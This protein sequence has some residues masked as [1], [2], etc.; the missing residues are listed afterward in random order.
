[1]LQIYSWQ[2]PC[3]RTDLVNRFAAV[4]VR[5]TAL[6][7]AMLCVYFGSV[8]IIHPI[9]Q[10]FYEMRVK[11]RKKTFNYNIQTNIYRMETNYL[12]TVWL[13]YQFIYLVKFLNIRIHFK[14]VGHKTV[15]ENFCSYIYRDEVVTGILKCDGTKRSVPEKGTGHRVK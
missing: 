8:H 7:A 14:T 2:I 3:S 5:F 13:P 11:R 12:I 4:E 10:N 15:S 1:M 6:S 9:K